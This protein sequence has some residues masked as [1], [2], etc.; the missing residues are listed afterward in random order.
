[1]TNAPHTSFRRNL[2][3]VMGLTC[4]SVGVYFYLWPPSLAS[5]E[6]LQGSCVKSG[7]VLIAA[8]LAYPQIDRMPGWVFVGM[9]GFLLSCGD[10]TASR[11]GCPAARIL[12]AANL[13][14]DLV[15]ATQEA[16][17]HD[18]LIANTQGHIANS[19]CRP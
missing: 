5:A 8:W 16:S 12:S 17:T 14:L 15:A 18:A 7:L 13:R 2:L 10:P 3:G 9:V 11:S 19:I 6:F 4:L 1:M